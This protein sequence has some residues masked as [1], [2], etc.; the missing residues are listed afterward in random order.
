MDRLKRPNGFRSRL[1]EQQKELADSLPLCHPNDD[2]LKDFAPM[3]AGNFFF[4]V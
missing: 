2:Y 4:Y 1:T 3:S